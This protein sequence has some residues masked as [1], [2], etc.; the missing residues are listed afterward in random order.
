MRALPWAMSRF[1]PDHGHLAEQSMSGWFAPFGPFG[2]EFLDPGAAA[3]S[4][5]FG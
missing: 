2:I 5:T 1:K 3:L 4:F